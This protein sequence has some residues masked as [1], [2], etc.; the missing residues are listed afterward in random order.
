[1]AGQA[2]GR[3]TF[4]PYLVTPEGSLRLP[5]EMLRVDGPGR[6]PIGEAPGWKTLDLPDGS[7]HVH[8]L[9]LGSEYFFRGEQPTVAYAPSFH[10][11]AGTRGGGLNALRHVLRGEA[12]AFSGRFF[13]L[14]E[15]T[16]FVMNSFE[17]HIDDMETLGVFV[18][19][20]GHSKR[21]SEVLTPGLY[22]AH[23]NPSKEKH[24]DWMKRSRV[25]SNVLKQRFLEH[26][27]KPLTD[28]EAAG[29]LQHHYIIGPTDVVDLTFDVNVAKWFSLNQ[30]VDG[31][32]RPKVF[33][34]TREP[35]DAMKEASC[36][37]T[38]TVRLIGQIELAGEAA[39]LFTPG[40]T[41]NWW[42][43]LAT[44]SSEPPKVET[45]PYNLARFGLSFREG[46]GVLGFVGSIRVNS[47]SWVQY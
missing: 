25:A 11:L 13:A 26:E 27:N 1:M 20:R 21:F 31:T 42:E 36:V 5:L 45:P 22:R 6:W 7:Q 43:G 14:P 16:Q 12:F 40:V 4:G 3:A 23:Q 37:Y 17:Y 35:K 18:G 33:R 34:E 10:H 2:R 19:F 41:L 15:A 46:R 47:T 44:P 30:F 9:A 28:L 8:W 32:Y 38:V 39:K 24:A 29:I